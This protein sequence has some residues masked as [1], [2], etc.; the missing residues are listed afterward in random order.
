MS[1]EELILEIKDTLAKFEELL[2]IALINNHLTIS[3]NGY[4]IGQRTN[5]FD[6]PFVELEVSDKKILYHNR[7]ISKT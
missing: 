2:N 5:E 6:K 4:Y 3:L 1:D 7:F